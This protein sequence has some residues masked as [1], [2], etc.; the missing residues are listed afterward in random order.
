MAPIYDYKALNAAGKSIKGTI[1]SENQKAARQKLKKQ[2]LTVV[3]IG[4]KTAKSTASSGGIPFLSGRISVREVSMATRQIASLVKANVPLVEAIAA[5]VDQTEKP[6][7]KWI[8]AQV[9]QDVNEGLTLAKATAKHPKAFDTIF[10]NMIEAGESSGTLGVVLIKLADLKE[11]QLRLRSKVIGGMT[12][13]V[14][15]LIVAT[16]LMVGIFT[17]VMPKLAGVFESMKKPM[18]PTTVFLM[19]VSDMLVSYWYAIG[20]AAFTA[21]SLFFKYIRSSTGKPKWDTFKLKMPI[22]GELVQ[23]IAVTRFSSTLS[24]LLS[25]GVPILNA[26]TIAKNLVDNIP[27]ANAIQQARENIT[28]GQSIAEPLKRSG[29]FPSMMLHMIAIGE[30]TGELPD[31]LQNVASNYEEQ[32]NTKI[33]SM[34]TLLEPIMIIGMGGMVGFIVLSVF[35]PLMEIQNVTK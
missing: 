26:M 20:A 1:D 4:E 7:L 22:F 17:F 28:E 19:W 11:A 31:M 32:V 29:M 14:L 9:K 27:I 23:L 5:V 2:G 15:M 25:S 6:A 18:P 24:T 16:G 33:D 3:D 12:Y 21:W 30:K 35:V 8:L 10:I 13:P 34:T